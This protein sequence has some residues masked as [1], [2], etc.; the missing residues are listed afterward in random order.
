VPQTAVTF[1]LYGDNVFVVVPDKKPDP[2]N[3][4]EQLEI[5]RRFVKAG[6]M[7]N[8]RVQIAEGLKP[9]DR[10]VTAGHNKIDQG[11]KVKIDNTVALRAANSATIQ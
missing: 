6:A 5:E 8:G 1:S 3:K 4:E 2:N 10:V 7:R 11:A 9:G